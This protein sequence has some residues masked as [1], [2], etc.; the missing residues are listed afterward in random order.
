MT[1]HILT[2]VGSG[3]ETWVSPLMLSQFPMPSGRM[4]HTASVVPTRYSSKPKP[5]P[6]SSR[7]SSPRSSSDGAATLAIVPDPTH[8]L[9][10]FGGSQGSKSVHKDFF[11]IDVSVVD[12]RSISLTPI[13][14]I[15]GFSPLPRTNHG[16][17]ILNEQVLI[18]IGGTS[19]DSHHD[20]AYML[21]LSDHACMRVT[22]DEDCP[23]LPSLT[24][25]AVFTIQLAKKKQI[26]CTH[27]GQNNG[28][29]SSKLLCLIPPGAESLKRPKVKKQKDIDNSASVKSRITTTS[30]SK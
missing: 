5:S 1:V 24:R 21:G 16:M 30:V 26:I 12:T 10:V 9:I 27:G 15:A 13:N 17:T 22:V 8:T 20:S 25:H 6:P 28:V 29:P 23:P 4:G 2:S 7:S 3:N 18:I 14:D 19:G 11:Q